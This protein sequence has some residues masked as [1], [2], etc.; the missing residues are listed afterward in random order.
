VPRNQKQTASV[1][2]TKAIGMES[3]KKTTGERDIAAP[4]R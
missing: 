2:E 3:M 4:K 1:V